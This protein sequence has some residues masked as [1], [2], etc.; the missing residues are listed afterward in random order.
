SLFQDD[1]YNDMR[2]QYAT[3][4]EK[5][6]APRFTSGKAVVRRTYVD[7]GRRSLLERLALQNEIKV[8]PKVLT[9]PKDPAE[10]NPEGY[11]QAQ[12]DIAKDFRRNG[13]A[14][15]VTGFLLEEFG[16]FN[17][18]N[19]VE[20]F[21]I[22][23]QE[24]GEA[25]PK[26]AF[27]CTEH[28]IRKLF[29]AMKKAKWITDERDSVSFSVNTG[30]NPFTFFDPNLLRATLADSPYNEEQLAAITERVQ[31]FLTRAQQARCNYTL[32]KDKHASTD[33]SITSAIEE[34][35]L[36]FRAAEDWM[37]A[38]LGRHHE[39]GLKEM[40][41][42]ILTEDYGKVSSIILDQHRPQIVDLLFS[43]NKRMSP[44]G[45]RELKHNND[46]TLRKLLPNITQDDIQQIREDFQKGG[47]ALLDDLLRAHHIPSLRNAFVRYL[48]H[49]TEWQHLNNVNK[50]AYTGERNKIELLAMRRHYSVDLIASAVGD[51][52]KEE[53]RHQLA[54]LLFEENIGFRCNAPQVRMFQSFLLKPDNPDAIDAAQA[55]MGFGKTA[56]LPIIALVK[57]ARMRES[58]RKDDLK[59][60]KKKMIRYVVPRA[61][62]EDNTYAFDQRLANILGAHVVKDTEF[63]RYQIDPDHS[64]DSLEL[65][66]SDL[67]ARKTFYEKVR[68]E[69]HLLIQSPEI[70]NSIES[71]EDDL[72]ELLHT[73]SNMSNDAKFALARCL[74]TLGTIRNMPTSTVFDEL[75]DTQDEK[76]RE[77]NYTQGERKST[78][79]VAINPMLTIIEQINSGG[80]DPKKPQA[81]ICAVLKKFDFKIKEN[82]PLITKLLNEKQA[83]ADGVDDNFDQHPRKEE[84]KA[85]CFLLRAL[86]SDESMLSMVK[87]KQPNTHFG[88]RFEEKE[89]KKNYFFDNQSG[90][91]SLIAVPYEGV[92]TPK[93]ASVYDNTEV[94]SFAT[95]RYYL[96]NETGF[97]QDPHLNFL[98]EQTKKGTIPNS[99]RVI[100]QDTKVLER[101]EA[102]ADML[103]QQEIL[104]AKQRFYKEFMAPPHT[105]VPQVFRCRRRRYTDTLRHRAHQQR[106]I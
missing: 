23:E 22:P 94:A 40:R 25:A 86:L 102:I 30:I 46:K 13:S 72:R 91:I 35:A 106:P 50:A 8:L 5:A 24:P 65:M 69:G 53:Q 75:D 41:Y 92:N 76:S 52:K 77:V 54:F 90:S 43:E 104:E 103:N 4:P 17:A 48:F 64:T 12:R 31:N 7:L 62:L 58:E 29:E 61:V 84:L 34:H 68:N 105:R 96:S 16:L 27:S 45:K 47:T 80:Y 26:G 28:D 19:L 1:A 36:E 59:P 32:A 39:V 21:S 3:T 11:Q 63:Q 18:S 88:V 67:D 56:L 60:E 66:Q 9:L 101:L 44:E 99:V 33:A 89:G 100:L 82:D 10:K 78:D 95:L 37:R 6:Y 38:K 20:L 73:R 83:I 79:P 93:G 2:T 57:L 15:Q 71:Q 97:E 42:A 74:D 81:F 85:T 51:A 55:R 98:I 87:D 14:D 70:R 49:K